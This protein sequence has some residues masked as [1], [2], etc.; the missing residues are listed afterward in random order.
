MASSDNTIQNVP[1]LNSHEIDEEMEQIIED[2]GTDKIT[3][4]L[5]PPPKSVD[6]LSVS[7]KKSDTGD[8]ENLESET[9]ADTNNSIII[10]IL[11][12]CQ[13]ERN[14]DKN[15]CRYAKKY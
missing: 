3:A 13:K 7:S 6:N 10:K 1:A 5:M 15:N 4:K 14:Y 2:N 9:D 8:E 12:L 11:K